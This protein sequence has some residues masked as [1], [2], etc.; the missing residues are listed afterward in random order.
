M[1]RPSPKARSSH[2]HGASTPSQ[3]S[4]T[5][6]SIWTTQGYSTS[7][8]SY[9]VSDVS[10]ESGGG[11]IWKY[12]Q[13]VYSSHS[14]SASK[15][16]K[17][18]S[19]PSHGALAAARTASSH[20]KLHKR[21]S[22][23]S[24][25]QSPLG[26]SAPTFEPQYPSTFT[27]TGSSTSPT[28]FGDTYTPS[29]PAS[30]TKTK[31]KPLLRKLATQEKNSLDLSRTAAEN[32]G[33]GIYTSSDLGAAS[34][35]GGDAPFTVAGRSAYHNRT[36]SGASEYSNTTT[37]SHHRPGAPYIHP[38]R[39]TPRPYTPPLAHSYQNSVVD[40]EYSGEATGFTLEEEHQLR[41]IVRDASYRPVTV[42]NPQP[43]LPPLHIHT[44]S[45]TLLAGS[46]Q[47]NL[48]GTPSSSLRR[49]RA[50]T[51][52][53]VD[54][55]SPISRSSIEMA[56]RLRSRADTDPVARAASIQAARQ[57]FSE[58]E[59]A[60]AKKAE[61]E[62]LRALERENRKREKRE[63]SQRRKGQGKERSGLKSSSSNEKQSTVQSTLYSDVPPASN[64]ANAAASMGGHGRVRRSNTNPS[65][66]STAKGRWL[67][68]LTWLRTKI[69]KLGKKVS[70][71]T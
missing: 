26:V 58:K 63:E 61:K 19:S 15:M 22:S 23:A 59:A 2:N 55:M 65:V 37:S 30:K 44:G 4:S 20:G 10:N 25:V 36:T 66:T 8:T 11:L 68:F 34:R 12:R 45:S 29:S 52:S 6:D 51:M 18:K 32:E 13:P 24:S 40:S 38:M 14:S 35:P 5:T 70:P 49:P 64:L 60:K 50:D 56:F 57:A 31:I 47:S 3:Y 39:Q 54:T 21:G 28:L 16:A 9:P 69:F 17:I 71:T 62:E 41:Q 46:S 1:A 7:G 67:Q 43:A 48:A 27:F 33:L 53:P 42:T